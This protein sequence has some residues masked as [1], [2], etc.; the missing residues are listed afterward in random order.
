MEK[1]KKTIIS[2]REF[3]AASTL[4]GAAL[5]IV[6]CYAVSGLGYVTPSDKLNIAG[7]GVGGIGLRNLNMITG[8][9][10]T[11]LCD[12]D[13]DYAAKA[14]NR[15]PDAKVYKD[16]REMLEKQK[17]IDAVLVATPDHT[18]AVVAMDSMKAGKHVYI[19]K[20]LALSV[21]ETRMLTE[22]PGNTR[23]RPKWGI[24]AIRASPYAG[25]VNGSGMEL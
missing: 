5:T 13:M 10:I 7:V 15:Y 3:L 4:T 19:E 20:P 16:Y 11:A 23:L 17:D 1:H 25:Y 6:P 9:N 2:R 12:V 18:H 24:R 14:F 22:R 21:Y 8:Q